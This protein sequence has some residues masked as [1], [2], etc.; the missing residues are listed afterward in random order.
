MTVERHGPSAEVT[1]GAGSTNG[2]DAGAESGGGAS[3]TTIGV[4]CIPPGQESEIGLTD[5]GKAM[6]ARHRATAGGLPSYR[7]VVDIDPSTGAISG[8]LRATIPVV[9][10]A[11]NFRVF[12]GTES[13]ESNMRIDNVTVDGAPAEFAVD[14]ALLTVDAPN[15]AD[16]PI[17]IGLDFSYAIGS[18]AANENPLGALSGET[19]QPDQ[20]GLLGR[21]ESG[22]QL[23]HWF[24]IW[25]PD[26]VRSD[27]DPSGFGDI[28]AFPTA[29][30]C[31]TITTPLGYEVVSGG[32]RVGEPIMTQTTTTVVEAA[33]GLRDLGLLV[34]N[35]IALTA[36]DVN[37][38][39][40]R[41]WGPT[42][43][44]E[45]SAIVLGYATQSLETL[46]DAFGP[47][48]WTEVDLVATP[49][50]GGVGGMEWPGMVWIERTAF[51]G[52]VPGLGDLG[53]LL[54]DA[55]D[56]ELIE[57]MLGQF[58]GEALTTTLEW[59]I[60]HELAH[61]WW[62]ANVGNDSIESPSVDEPLAQFG[63]CLAMERIHPDSW[64]D[65]CEAQTIDQYG[66]AR[67]LGITDTIAEQPSDGFDSAIQ[68]G[69]V[70]YGKAPG[71]YFEAA[72]LIGWPELTAA[73]HSFI[74]ENSFAL[75]STDV[76][77]A[78]LIEASGDAGPQI[79]ALWDRWF[80]EA[81]GD[82]DIEITDPLAGLGGLQ[83]LEGVDLDELFA[84]L[85]PELAELFEDLLG[86]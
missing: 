25:L 56:P 8:A 48:P 1:P 7:L 42:A 6:L 27:A 61:E 44:R 62:H 77:R 14:R 85:D 13:F 69:A 28:G 39:E 5:D 60:A 74:D 57:S 46:A 75:V 72:D 68:Y 78:H 34:S 81:K 51:A 10:E 12:A 22:M 49:L 23:G 2:R 82:E 17:E 26:S 67:A 59:V 11:V 40:I 83:G 54:G 53:A 76:L 31:A 65:I 64:R 29:D 19:L 45:S 71:F 20:V 9:D 3:G 24:P 35:D 43:N 63:A 16:G 79:G 52:G 37:G 80:R 21:T 41:V 30:I 32:V 66:Q 36:A 55:V 70:V 38:V 47:Y 84:D 73:L 50:G 86:G 15:S 18:M 33:S 58:G 4:E